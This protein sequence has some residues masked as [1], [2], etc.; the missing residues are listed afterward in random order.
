MSQIKELANAPVVSII[1]HTTLQETR[2][3]AI[4]AYIKHYKE[5]TGEDIELAPA[6]P[7]RLL[8]LSMA[9]IEHQTR[10]MA[11]AKYEQE[12]LN[13]S[14]GEALDQLALIPG[15]TRNS[16]AY[17]VATERFH[18]QEPLEQ[19]IAI[20]AGTRVKTQNEQYFNTLSYAEIKKG[21]TY[22]D[23]TIQAEEAGTGSS[24]IIVGQINTLVDPIPYVSSV[25]NTTESEGGTDIED[26]DSL[27]RRVYLAPSGFSSAGPEDAYKYFCAAWRSD[28][29]DIKIVAPETEPCNIYIYFV[30]EGGRLPTDTELESMR[31][32]ISA[33]TMRPLGDHVF[34][35]RPAEISYEVNFTYWIATSDQQSAGTI[36]D[37]IKAAVADYETWQRKIGRDINPSELIMRIRAAGAK[38]VKVTAP[39]DIV[40]KETELPK[41]SKETITYGGLEDD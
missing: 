38:R 17:A 26:D 33:K 22:V 21:E 9:D 18:I 16:A 34:C 13:T 10:Q 4:N 14:T 7:K 5:L 6:D 20:P 23:T 12:M 36:Q 35:K 19:V 39:A 25:E 2:D 40:I 31:S 32:Y 28:V 3:E 8:L 1:E 30:L 11:Q 41:C 37:K 29:D 15:L 24:G 27:T